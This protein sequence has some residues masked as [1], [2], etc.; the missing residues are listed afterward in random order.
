M[1]DFVVKFGAPTSLYRNGPLAANEWLRNAQSV[2]F[3]RVLGVGDGAQRTSTGNNKGKV[4]YAG[5]VVGDR[6]PQSTLSGNLGN[7]QYAVAG[8]DLGK[9]YFLA[10][11]MSQSSNSA[12]FTDAGLSASGQM[13]LRGVLMAASGVALTLSSSTAPSTAPN[14]LSSSATKTRQAQYNQGS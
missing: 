9:T 2:T 11:Y 4:Q 7:S 1:N 13:V 10:T 3:L 12:I 6:Q 5:F 14:I 8:G